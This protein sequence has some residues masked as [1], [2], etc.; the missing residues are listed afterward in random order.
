MEKNL[1]TQ[2]EEENNI[3]KQLNSQNRYSHMLSGFT[4]QT[5]L[6][7]YHF[8]T[9]LD[10]GSGAGDHAK[11]FHDA[12]KKVTTIDY[13]VSKYYQNRSEN[14]KIIFSDYNTYTFQSQFDLVWASHILEHQLNPGL[15]LKKFILI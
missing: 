11:I 8:D 4:L 12:G 3:L 2:N 5:L 6:D 13:G 10:I 7:Y 15:F 1:F 9:I 14:Y